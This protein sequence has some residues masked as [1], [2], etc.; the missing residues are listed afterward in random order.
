MCVLLVLRSGK[1]RAPGCTTQDA[2]VVTLVENLQKA[3]RQQ[4]V[5]FPRNWPDS[6]GRASIC[7]GW[8]C[9]FG[10]NLNPVG[11]QLGRET[12]RIRLN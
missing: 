9:L 8:P 2:D 7:K 10:S 3:I 1:R 11:L 4:T 12:L 5:T 6:Q